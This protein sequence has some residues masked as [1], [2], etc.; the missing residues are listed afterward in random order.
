MADDTR[1]IRMDDH[2]QLPQPPF[3]FRIPCAADASGER[4][5]FLS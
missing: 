5:I 2:V 3:P 1:V 4:F